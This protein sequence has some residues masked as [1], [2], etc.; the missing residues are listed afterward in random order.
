MEFDYHATHNFC[1]STSE[2]KYMGLNPLASFG[3]VCWI[4]TSNQSR[5]SHST[6][7]SAMLKYAY[8]TVNQPWTQ[9]QLAPNNPT[10]SRPTP[11]PL[12]NCR[13]RDFATK[14]PTNA[15]SPQRKPKIQI[16]QEIYSPRI[17]YHGFINV[18]VDIGHP[19]K[20]LGS[21]IPKV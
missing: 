18:R 2:A 21:S 1:Q 20:L 10:T 16:G 8:T 5:D 14:L 19:Q 15:H 4:Q 9:C 6:H 3:H 13:P 12:Y 11:N 17:E 7:Q